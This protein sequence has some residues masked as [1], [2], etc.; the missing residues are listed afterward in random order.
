LA[1]QLAEYLLKQERG[2]GRRA[3]LQKQLPD[4]ELLRRLAAINGVEEN[5]GVNGRCTSAPTLVL[6]AIGRNPRLATSAVISSGRSRVSAASS[7]DRSIDR[8]RMRKWRMKSRPPGAEEAV[9]RRRWI[10]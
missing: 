1:P 5:I 10:D 4:L 7:T 3:Q 2:L 9:D 8:L 6:R